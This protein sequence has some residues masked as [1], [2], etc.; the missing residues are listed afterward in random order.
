[1]IG[2]AGKE[3]DED[4]AIEWVNGQIKS[5]QVGAPDEIYFKG[6]VYKG[7][8]FCKFD[9]QEKAD[10]V[11]KE[12]T[13][14]TPEFKANASVYKPWFKQDAP[15]EQRAPLSFLLGLRCQLGEW[16]EDKEANRS[17]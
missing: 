16:G 2:G 7:L 17:R 15:I 13:R 11:I 4:E 12:L 3:Q 14:R 8:L 9:N 10:K 5:L 1:V 6:E